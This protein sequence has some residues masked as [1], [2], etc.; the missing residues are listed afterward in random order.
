MNASSVLAVALGVALA[1]AVAALVITEL[2]GRSA[3]PARRRAT[4]DVT[5]RAALDVIDLGLR[6]LT[7]DCARAGRALPDVYAV[8]YSG[9]RL[10]L[11]LATADR[12]APESWAAD[13]AGDEWRAEPA[14][15]DR[16]GGGPLVGQPFS[17]A[18]T[19]GIEDG[20][21]VLVDLSRS[22]APTAVTG[23]AADVRG[24]VGALVAELITGPVGRLAEVTLV[25]SAATSEL[26]G[27]LGLHSA[28]LH[29]VATLE[30]ALSGGES[31]AAAGG[32]PGDPAVTQIYLQIVGGGPVSVAGRTPR[33]FVLDA[34]N[35]R[36]E[37][38]ALGRLR[39][40]DAL[41]V[42]GDVADAGWRFEV[43][44]DGALDTGPLGLK[45]DVHTGRM[46]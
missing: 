1:G 18:V 26:T 31:A 44:S 9:Q 3:A 4:P 41:L 42:I 30:E 22:S 5:G 2:R 16:A 32:A 46:G 11:R 36:H 35:F 7:E 29:T 28:R 14:G 21:R 6:R 40:S 15:L 43:T 33:L 10:G 19:I 27:G 12:D 8:V 23:E 37:Q 25:G 24:F 20:E 39:A 13:E 38:A 34:A 17:L 45:I